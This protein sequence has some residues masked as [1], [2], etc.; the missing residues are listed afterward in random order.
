MK[1]LLNFAGLNILPFIINLYLKTIRINIS[2]KPIRVKKAVYI[3]WH[4]RMLI[5]WWLFKNNNASALVSQ[6]K[7]GSI[8][9]NILEKWDYKIIRGSSSKGSKDALNELIKS[10]NEDRNIVITPDGPR[11]PVKLI[12]NGALIISNQCQIPI[13]PV[14]INYSHKI[15]LKSS[16]DKFEI[17]I[18]FSKCEVSFG[19]EYFYKEY[20]EEKELSD[21][22]QK[23]S[24]EM[25]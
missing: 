18:P 4:S 11:G 10:A 13:I 22:K 17:P 8:L 12:K 1:S 23:L 24:D 16:W 6:S 15:I 14:R 2:N 3:F 21:V 7:D 5:G 9:N 19:K 20:L 25:E